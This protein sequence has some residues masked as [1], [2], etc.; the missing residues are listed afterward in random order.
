MSKLAPNEPEAKQQGRHGWS[1]EGG[2]GGGGETPSPLGLPHFSATLSH[3]AV[4]YLPYREIAWT[5]KHI[6]Q[7]WESRGGHGTGN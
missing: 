6:S 4:P 7:G 2:D 5:E 3:Q 1:G